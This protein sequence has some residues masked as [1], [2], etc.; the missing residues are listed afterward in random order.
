MK[1]KTK[2]L[3]SIFAAS[4]VSLTACFTP[5]QQIAVGSAEIGN[6][7]ATYELNK[8]GSA[9]IKGL[10]DLATNLP[11]IPL[12][13]VSANE[14]GIINAELQQVQSGQ[15]KS[16]QLY[17]QVGSLIAL[18]SQSAATAGGNPTLEAGQ[19]V[20]EATDVSNGINNAIQ[21]WQG[22]Q[23]VTPTKPAGN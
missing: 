4:L 6:A 23:S 21:Y 17:A 10:Q 13:K 22:G 20:A 2:V 16:S 14:L 19:L 8:D 5:T 3:V 12:G 1:T 11:L 15:V 7:L 18:V 9:A